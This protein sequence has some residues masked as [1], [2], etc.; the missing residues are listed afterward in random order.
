MNFLDQETGMAELERLLNDQLPT[1]PKLHRGQLKNDLRYIILPNKNP[2]NRY[3]L[4]RIAFSIDCFQ[5]PMEN[6]T[7]YYK[8][9]HV[10]LSNLFS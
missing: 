7:Q 1:H 3:N 2:A 4:Y 9:Y 8:F 6:R 10:L 5:L